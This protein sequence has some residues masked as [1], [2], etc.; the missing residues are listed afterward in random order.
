[1]KLKKFEKIVKEVTESMINGLGIEDVVEVEYDIKE[2]DDGRFSVRVNILGSDLGYLIGP[3]GSHLQSVRQVIALIISKRTDYEVE[4][5]LIVDAGGYIDESIE[6]L[7]EIAMRKADDARIMGSAVDL[8]PMN[9]FAR[10]IIHDTIGRFDDVTSESH[11]KGLGRHVRITPV[12]DSEL[13]IGTKQG[14]SSEE[15]EEE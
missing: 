7:E 10:K 8:Q 15:G 11:G 1:M 14:D 6:K 13:G 9:A 4:Y 5:D 2:N 12:S 3:Q